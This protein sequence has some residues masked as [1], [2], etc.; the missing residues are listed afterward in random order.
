LSVCAL[1]LL[2]AC[3]SDK[4]KSSPTTTTTTTAETSTTTTSTGTETTT[5]TAPVTTTTASQSATTTTIANTS[6]VKITGFTYIGDNPVVCNAPTQVELKW[7]TSGATKVV[8]AIDGDGAFANYPNG[9][10]D[11]LFPLSC[12]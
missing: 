1:T 12:D 2:A 4:K 11:A 6:S 3:S 10:K 8:L 9:P 5:T 7:N